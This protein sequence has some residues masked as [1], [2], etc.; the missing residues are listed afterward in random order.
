ML[1]T[2]SLKH[3]YVLK[4]TRFRLKKKLSRW[5]V[6]STQ[7]GV[8][9]VPGSKLCTAEPLER[10]QRVGEG[11]GC[12]KMEAEHVSP[13]P[14]L[15]RQSEKREI[16]AKRERQ[17]R[18]GGKQQRVRPLDWPQCWPGRERER[19]VKRLEEIR[20]R[21]D[22][23]SNERPRR[24]IIGKSAGQKLTENTGHWNTDTFRIEKRFL[25]VCYLSNKKAVVIRNNQRVALP[26]FDPKKSWRTEG[27]IHR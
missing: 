16:T 18:G 1:R 10:Y 23:M 14:L 8:A 7:I 2:V 3:T 22:R 20:E 25:C 11:T 24:A 9:H 13:F 4:R 21:P 27:C 6:L 15:S 12:S 17:A 5:I 19:E 26:L